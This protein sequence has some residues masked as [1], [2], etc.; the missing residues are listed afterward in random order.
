[1]SLKLKLIRKQAFGELDAQSQ[2][3]KA[4]WIEILRRLREALEQTFRC[5]SRC[6][7]DDAEK[8]LGSDSP[9]EQDGSVQWSAVREKY[10]QL[11]HNCINM[12][13]ELNSNPMTSQ[14]VEYLQAA[15]NFFNKTRVSGCSS[16]PSTVAPKSASSKHESQKVMAW[17]AT[18]EGM[19]GSVFAVA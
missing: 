2:V 18:E 1:M 6:I 3:E 7:D 13:L 11:S 4:S 15:V 12:L 16:G 14:V 17:E 9:E 19:K 10:V 5:L 8:I